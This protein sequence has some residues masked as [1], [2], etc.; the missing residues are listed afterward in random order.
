MLQQQQV[1]QQQ[2]NPAAA[3][4]HEMNRGVQVLNQPLYPSN[5]GAS[6]APPTMAAPAAVDAAAG[7]APTATAQPKS[8]SATL[9]DAHLD[10]FETALRELG[11]AF[12]SDLVHVEEQDL[13]EIGMK[14]MEVK[15]LMRVAAETC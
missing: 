15:R 2:V 14:K 12:A 6:Y 13:V 8:L 7:A 9:A 4:A 10:Q 1:V 3:S 11:V 5:A